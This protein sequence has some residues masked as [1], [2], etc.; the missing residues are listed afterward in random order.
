MPEEF[1]L[2]DLNNK[3][4]I[5]NQ[6]KKLRNECPVYWSNEYKTWIIT[7]YDDV[8][9]GLRDYRTFSCTYGN[10]TV[11][12]DLLAKDSIDSNTS[13]TSVMDPPESLKQRKIYNELIDISI[14][15]N[16]ENFIKDNIDMLFDNIKNKNQIDFISNITNIIATDAIW[17]MLEF[18]N[19]D[20]L[21]VREWSQMFWT[22]S[23]SKNRIDM[24]RNAANFIIDSKPNIFNYG[25]NFKDVLNYCM[26]LLI[27]GSCSMS[28]ALPSLLLN[29]FNYPDQISI[30][31][32]N[33]EMTDNFINESLRHSFMYTHIIRTTT[34]DILKNNILIKEGQPVA[35]FM[36]SA[37]FDESHYGDNVDNFCIDRDFKNI[38]FVFGNGPHVCVGNKIAMLQLKLFLHK[39]IDIYDYIKI[40]SYTNVSEANYTGGTIKKIYGSYYSR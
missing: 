40:D 24:Y 28:N 6:F 18:S 31:K 39:L 1:D 10:S 38:N 27:G 11:T 19:S 3:N 16:L 36:S 20:R 25:Y 30:V 35:F 21:K 34:R 26:G 23:T 17:K 8:D 32:N 5:I 29:T 15:N 13:S 14:K 9:Q 2:S 22:P 4:K 37:N 12:R 33:I 7:R